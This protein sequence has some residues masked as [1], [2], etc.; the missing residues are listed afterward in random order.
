MWKSH[1]CLQKLYRASSNEEGSSSSP[2][3]P[4]QL[5]V[6]SPDGIQARAVE[7]GKERSLDLD[8]IFSELPIP[9][10]DI[11]NKGFI[12]IILDTLIP[13]PTGNLEG[14]SFLNSM[15]S[16]LKKNKKILEKIEEREGKFYA[17]KD[18]WS[19]LVKGNGNEVNR[20]TID[21]TLKTIDEQI[22]YHEELL[23]KKNNE[24]RREREPD[25]GRR[26]RSRD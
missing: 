9:D 15:I 1:I 13:E 8:E 3:R 19:P 14:L 17:Y 6:V 18:S 24:L 21:E 23:V 25:T 4:P 12:P 20:L 10:F 16:R 2:P 26:S 5:S 22:E 11:S 7:G